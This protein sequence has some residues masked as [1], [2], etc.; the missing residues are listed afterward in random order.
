[1]AVDLVGDRTDLEGEMALKIDLEGDDS[2]G[3]SCLWL[4]DR[5]LTKKTFNAYGFL[6][7]MKRAM[8]SAHGFTGKEI[9]K[10]LVSFHFNIATDMAGVMAWEPWHFDKNIILLKELKSDE[11]P[12]SV[13]LDKAI[14]W[15][16]MYDLSKGARK[17]SIIK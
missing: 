14:F 15:I 12:S 17:E 2:L 13:V 7:T 1:M 6:E 10:N 9:G 16:R 11:K 4:I 8:N 3:S 5:V